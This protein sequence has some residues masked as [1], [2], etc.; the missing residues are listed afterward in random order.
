MKEFKRIGLQWFSDPAP[1]PGVEFEIDPEID[2]DGIDRTQIPELN[3]ESMPADQYDIT[4]GEGEPEVETPESKEAL[5]AEV[6][7]L[8]ENLEGLAAQADTNKALR[9]AVQDLGK[10]IQPQAPV[11]QQPQA[12]VETEE[13]FKKRVDEGQF[14]GSLYDLMAEFQKRKI[15]PEV[16]SILQSNLYHSKRFVELD[17]KMGL[18]F[19]KYE[20]EI[21]NEI[22]QLP[23]VQKLKVPDIYKK[24]TE[25]VASRH[26][27]EIMSETVEA[28]VAEEVKKQ[29][30]KAGL[31]VGGKP[32]T[33]AAPN[34]SENSPHRPPTGA[35]V[36]EKIRGRLTFKEDA[37]A[38]RKGIPKHQLWESLKSKPDLKK[39]IEEGSI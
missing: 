2:D 6:A 8:K 35:P 11:M 36:G 13:E 39:Q 19:K 21:E 22:A 3:F 29:L 27:D 25:L 33:P 12:P 28:R 26:M 1:A 20:S 9:E 32:A 23:P 5:I 10:N 37:F 18:V 15:G 7:K 31:Q 16:Q 17:P 24:V 34:W 4:V 14:E 38:L 30:E